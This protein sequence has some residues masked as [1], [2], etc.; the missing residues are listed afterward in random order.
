MANGHRKVR[1]RKH[2][3]RK[4]R[5]T[6]C[7]T[8]DSQISARVERYLNGEVQANLPGSPGRG[9]ARGSGGLGQPSP[10]WRRLSPIWT[11]DQDELLEIGEMDLFS[12]PAS[13][14][15]DRRPF[16]PKCERGNESAHFS[17]PLHTYLI[18]Y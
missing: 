9:R 15:G 7:T 13:V 4:Q 14:G 17:E 10:V 2:L 3:T 1:Q 16:I 6:L 18:Y 8:V 12:R 11:G 5:Q